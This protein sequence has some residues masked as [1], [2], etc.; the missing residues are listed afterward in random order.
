MHNTISLGCITEGDDLPQD[1]ARAIELYEKTAAQEHAD[2]Q[3]DLAKIY[4]IATPL[5]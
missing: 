1:I 2:A 5:E 4:Y 3:H